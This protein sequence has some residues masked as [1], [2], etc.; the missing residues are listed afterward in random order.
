MVYLRDQ[1]RA[2]EE[3]REAGA[4]LRQG[5][6]WYQKNRNDKEAVSEA[7][8]LAEGNMIEAALFHHKKAQD[9]REKAEAARDDRLMNQAAEEYKI[10]S[11]HYPALPPR[12]T[13]TRRT[14]TS[15]A[16]ASPTRSTSPFQFDKAAEQYMKV[17]DSNLDNKYFEESARC[18]AG[19]TR[20][21][22]A[23]DSEG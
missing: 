4:Q 8:R 19:P 1:K 14:S 16:T 11:E 17:R 3:T 12:S 23:P 15:T 21:D 18:G 20:A 9:L 7:K 2:I 5:T 22:P 6:D 13:R 10:A